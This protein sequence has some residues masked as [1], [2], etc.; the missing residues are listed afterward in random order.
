MDS[1]P[2]TEDG[3]KRLLEEY[4]AL[5]KVELP[6]TIKRVAEA[7]AHGDLKENA[8][9]HA[10]REHQSY[11]QG[12]I[13]FL[14]DRIARSV[15]MKNQPAVGDTVI[16][17]CKVKVLDIEDDFEEVY[18]LVGQAEAEPSKGRISTASPIGKSLLG[19]KVGDTIEAE[20]PGGIF[21][22]KI[23]EIGPA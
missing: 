7:R 2:I 11:L 1:I 10:A 20:T 5:K 21:K 16:F 4:D 13:E 17:G 22:M 19:K 8:E 9:Y 12:R 23:L 15:I 18:V 3:Y 6:A 14:G